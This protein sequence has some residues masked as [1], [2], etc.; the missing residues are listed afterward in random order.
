MDG[1]SCVFSS[2]VY[3]LPS[4]PET[5]QILISKK[6]LK[7]KKNNTDNPNALVLRIKFPQTYPIIYKTVR[8]DGNMHVRDALAFI[9]ESLHVQYDVNVGLFLPDNKIWLDDNLKLSD[10]GQLY[11][12]VF[13]FP[14][15]IFS[16][17]FFFCLLTFPP[18]KKGVGIRR[19]QNPRRWLLQWLS[20]NVTVSSRSL[21]FFWMVASSVVSALLSEQQKTI[22]LHHLSPFLPRLLV[23]S[24]P[25]RFRFWFSRHR[26]GESI[27]L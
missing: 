14:C 3:S 6:F 26:N 16:P 1:I 20:D 4:P 12:E 27:D 23:S 8:L 17:F 21:F 13:P 10:Y 11:E 15:S 2:F 5:K 18:M 9:A 25:R 7:Q 22:L 19:I 24:L